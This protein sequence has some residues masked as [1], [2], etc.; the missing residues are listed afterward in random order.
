MSIVLLVVFYTILI[1][2]FPSG[3]GA[4][5][6]L[7]THLQCCPTLK[8]TH[9]FL[10]TYERHLNMLS[11]H[12]LEALDLTHYLF[13]GQVHTV[14]TYFC[15]FSNANI[16]ASRLFLGD[17][18]CTIVFSTLELYCLHLLSTIIE[19]NLSS[20]GSSNIEHVKTQKR[21]VYLTDNFYDIDNSTT[22]MNQ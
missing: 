18:E 6:D 16:F 20:Y 3:G 11:Y 7:I 22:T 5:D 9:V 12:P 10:K 13:I 19:Y 1:V 21:H 2:S 17:L 4:V 8:H 15:T 14:C